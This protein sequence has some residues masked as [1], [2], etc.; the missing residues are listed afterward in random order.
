MGRNAGLTEQKLL[1][2]ASYETST[3]FAA[4]ERLVLRLTDALTSTPADVASELYAALAK[5][6]SQEQLVEL[7][8]AIAWEN[9][10]ARNNRMFDVGSEDYTEGAFCPMPVR[11]SQ[12]AD[13]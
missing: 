3:A 13:E 7:A 5:M 8:S 12:S 2:L 9:Y 4:E 1:E 11:T 10:R 6:F